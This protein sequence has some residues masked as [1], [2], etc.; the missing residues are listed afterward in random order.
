MV[1]AVSSETVGYSSRD[2]IMDSRSS[3]GS[4]GR[5]KLWP[6]REVWE[7]ASLLPMAPPRAALEGPGPGLRPVHTGHVGT[8]GCQA[9]QAG[10]GVLGQPW[11]PRSDK[12]WPALLESRVRQGPPGCLFRVGVH[13]PPSQGLF[14]F[15]FH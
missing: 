1:S 4:M 5:V 15:S 13:T 11:G 2:R 6:C 3:K 9:S 7:L 14:L 8:E 12:S 10:E